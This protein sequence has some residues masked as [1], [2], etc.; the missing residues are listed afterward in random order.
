MK[1]IKGKPLKPDTGFIRDQLTRGRKDNIEEF[2][3][4]TPKE[5][6]EKDKKDSPHSKNRFSELE[7]FN[8]TINQDTSLLNNILKRKKR[9]KEEFEILEKKKSELLKKK[10]LLE[11]KH[12]QLEK[13]DKIF[14]R[15]V[16]EIKNEEKKA[17]AELTKD[18]EM[19]KN[20]MDFIKDENRLSKEIAKTICKEPLTKI[21]NLDK[22]DLD[23]ISSLLEKEKELHNKIQDR[24]EKRYSDI[25]MQ[26][27]PGP[28]SDLFNYIRKHREWLEKRAKEL[29]TG[30]WDNL[31]NFFHSKSKEK[32][33]TEQTKEKEEKS[34]EKE[35]KNTKET[36][37]K[38]PGKTSEEE[39]SGEK[40]NKDTKE[41]ESKESGK[42]SE[43]KKSTSK[44]ATTKKTSPKDQDTHKK[45]DKES[46]KEKINEVD[47]LISE[48]MGALAMDNDE[49]AKE[50]MKKA[51][52]IYINF[53]GNI[54]DKQRIY[55][56]LT[57]LQKLMA[58]KK[59]NT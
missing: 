51:K 15:D 29:E 53:D 59:S 20:D 23:S 37:S 9:L 35:N 34:G 50:Y 16:E 32:K 46:E 33:K 14:A 18:E 47:E 49:K 31:D 21:D 44:K 24:L 5:S 39:K 4:E 55:E 57:E 56:E 8:N 7:F 30:N 1:G 27:L 36:K 17:I 3:K 26:D 52:D 58:L 45:K 22:A 41:T 42:V 25:I 12:R 11:R 48:I 38:E 54:I 13:E 43:K 19:L 40:E 10:E 28:A 6:F 2:V